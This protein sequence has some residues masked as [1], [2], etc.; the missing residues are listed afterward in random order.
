VSIGTQLQTVMAMLTC[1][2]LMGMGFDTYHVFKGKSRLPGWIVF[3]CDLLFWLGSM[4]LVFLILVKVN[5]GF[6]RFPIFFGVIIGAWLYFVVGS[7][8]YIH[9]LHRVIEFSQWLYR[10]ILLVIDTLL[11]R[12]ILFFYRAILMLLAFLYSVLLWIIGFVW[13]LTRFVT[14][15]FARWGQHLG[16][17]MFGK[18]KGFWK[19]WKNWFPL[20]RKRE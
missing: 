8:K 15:P 18:T 12:P 6:I 7:K 2:A 13:K 10:T 20:K 1:G 3:I 4:A 14:S 9:F 11:V 17:K 16:K 5:D 19:N